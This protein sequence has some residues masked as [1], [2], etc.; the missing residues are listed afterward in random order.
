[1]ILKKISHIGLLLFFAATFITCNN[2]LK[3]RFVV[4]SDTHLG[5]N[6]SHE[7]VPRTLKCLLSKKPVPDAIFVV[8]DL[9]NNG[10][11]QEYDGLLEIFSDPTIVPKGIAVYYMTGNHEFRKIIYSETSTKIETCDSI[12]EKNLIFEDMTALE[13]FTTKTGQPPHQ[14]IDIKGYPFITISMTDG[15]NLIGTMPDHDVIN[16][17]YNDD[18]LYFLSKKM[19]EAEHSYP[20]KPI[21]LFSHIGSTSTCF[22]TFPKDDGGQNQFPPL[23]DKYPQTVF[24]NGHSHFPIG[25]PRTIHQ[26]NY[27]SINTGSSAFPS[28]E[29]YYIPNPLLPQN[30]YPEVTEGLIVNVFSDGNI[31]IERWDTFRNEEILPRWYLKPPFDGSNFI[32]K[33]RDGLPAPSFESGAK[34]TCFIEGSSL[35]VRFPKANDDEIVNH[36]TIDFLNEEGN[37][38]HS[39]DRFSDFPQNSQMPEIYVVRIPLGEN[40]LLQ[41]PSCTNIQIRVTAVDSYCNRSESISSEMFNIPSVFLKESL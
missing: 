2:D 27:T 22:G 28:G 15:D 18:A 32:Y 10:W 26:G 40:S 7:N 24:F 4:I 12:Q 33:D 35:I 17:L 13:R 39:G 30:S 3:L 41:L 20:G 11:A 34:V 1:M 38:F 31:E 21:F 9:T 36:Y 14:Y 29:K 16:N 23:L 5:A 25:D 6:R 8:G 19:E 37:V